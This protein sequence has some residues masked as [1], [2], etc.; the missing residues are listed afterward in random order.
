LGSIAYSDFG[1]EAYYS[2]GNIDADT[3]TIMKSLSDANVKVAVNQAN[4]YAAALADCIFDAPM[5]SASHDAFDVDVPF[6]Q[7]VFKGFVPMVSNPVNLAHSG[8]KQVLKS[9]ESGTALGFALMSDYDVILAETY[10]H[11]FYGALYD[12]NKQYIKDVVKECE[13]YYK[14]IYGAS[15]K[16]HY[17]LS[18]NVT[19]TVFDNGVIVFTNQGSQTVELPEG[20]I[21]AEEF[22]FAKAYQRH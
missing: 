1:D 8:R 11:E 5:H 18:G 10:H 9:I 17:I 16:E 22:I 19:K 20:T 3:A 2:K 14:A 21:K 12:D 13:D 4:G 7:I 6:Y 15:I